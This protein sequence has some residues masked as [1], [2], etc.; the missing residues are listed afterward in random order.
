MT[1][2][3]IFIVEDEALIQIML[4]DMLE[5][6]GHQVIAVAGNI[7]VARSLAEIE[8]Y[9]LAIL[10]I[11]LQGSS[12]QPVAQIVAERNL[13]FFF[14]TGYSTADAPQGFEEASVLSKP[15]TQ[16]GIEQAI[17]TVLSRQKTH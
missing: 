6:L 13:P 12:V 7:E 16:R 11:N 17:D 9:D 3:S 4:V 8:D 1:P 14:L 5:E 2:A 10:D 15:C